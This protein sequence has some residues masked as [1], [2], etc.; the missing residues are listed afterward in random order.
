MAA[1]GPPPRAAL[2]SSHGV[3]RPV[4]ERPSPR[5]FP[6][7]IHRAR[8]HWQPLR[9][10][11]SSGL[12][13]VEKGLRYWKSSSKSC[14]EEGNTTNRDVKRALDALSDAFA[15]GRGR[16]SSN[17]WLCLQ[18]KHYKLCCCSIITSGNVSHPCSTF[19]VRICWD[20]ICICLPII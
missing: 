18:L 7:P 20:S 5:P 4:H 11:T 10:D 14:L 15:G 19:A 16:Q 6:M 8:P 1:A 13:A 9:P 2:S 3:S 12:A 17:V